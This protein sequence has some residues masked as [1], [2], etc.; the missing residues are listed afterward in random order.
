M[1]GYIV[2]LSGF[3]AGFLSLAAIAAAAT[4]VPR[5]GDAGDGGDRGQLAT[6]G[7][8]RGG[9]RMRTGGTTLSESG[10][11]RHGPPPARPPSPGLPGEG[12]HRPLPQ[13]RRGCEGRVR[14]AGGA[15]P[16]SKGLRLQ[17][18]S[19]QTRSSPPS[20]YPPSDA[21]GSGRRAGARGCPACCRRWRCHHRAEVDERLEL[22]EPQRRRSRRRRPGSRG[23]RRGR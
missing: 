5:P 17:V 1:A 4:L 13:S 22:A 23:A 14:S 16:S 2:K 21:P 19:V 15:E 8:G 12:A 20:S 18:L 9:R 3:D 7:V 6:R 11:E 10:P